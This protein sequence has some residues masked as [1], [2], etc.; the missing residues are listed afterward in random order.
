M[1]VLITGS[2]GFIGQNLKFNLI[3]EKIEVIEFTRKSNPNILKDLVEK[4]DI[5]F[6]LAGENRSKKKVNFYNNNYIL[7]KKI[8]NCVIKSKNETL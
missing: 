4:V 8:I 5:I 3:S 7:T 2:N 1:K 6:H